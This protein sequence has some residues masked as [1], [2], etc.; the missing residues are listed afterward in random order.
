MSTWFYLSLHTPEITGNGLS[1]QRLK[2]FYCDTFGWL[3]GMFLFT[4]CHPPFQITHV[5]V[6]N[7]CCNRFTRH[8][9]N[10]SG[11]WRFSRP[12]CVCSRQ[13]LTGYRSCR[14]A[15][16]SA[17]FTRDGVK[18]FETH[19]RIICRRT[20]RHIQYEYT[21]IT[22]KLLTPPFPNENERFFRQ[23]E[24]RIILRCLLWG[25]NPSLD[26]LNQD[27]KKEKESTFERNFYVALTP[28]TSLP[29]KTAIPCILSLNFENREE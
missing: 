9:T 24:I 8:K 6:L 18:K 16:S 4:F 2:E 5:E 22:L 15:I 20:R 3:Q 25:L 14:C 12:L 17:L 26:R 21:R 10:D 11:G 29:V 23:L 19:R 7:K 27:R 28:S 1:E 13:T